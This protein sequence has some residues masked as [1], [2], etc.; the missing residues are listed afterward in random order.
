MA[1]F[2]DIT[3]SAVTAHHDTKLDPPAS[4]EAVAEF[5]GRHGVDRT[6]GSGNVKITLAFPEWKEARVAPGTFEI[7]VADE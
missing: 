6:I 1:Y 3:W 4:A 5:E 7:P 2:D